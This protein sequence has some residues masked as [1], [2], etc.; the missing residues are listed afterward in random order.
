MKTAKLIII[1]ILAFGTLFSLAVSV[2]GNHAIDTIAQAQAQPET[3]TDIIMRSRSQ[4]AVEPERRGNTG[5]LGA[6]LLALVL[7]VMG[8]AVFVMRGG[9]DLL[10]QWRLARKQQAQPGRPYVPTLRQVPRM[11]PAQQER[12]L[13]NEWSEIDERQNVNHTG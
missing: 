6:G 5:W 2:V 12:P 11:Q 4:P 7:V 9:T 10:K 8:T 13:L 3:A 1:L